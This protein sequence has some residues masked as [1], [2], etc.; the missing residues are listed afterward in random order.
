MAA[1]VSERFDIENTYTFL[2]RDEKGGIKKDEAQIEKNKIQMREKQTAIG[3]L[4]ENF[5]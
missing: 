3:V 4:V 2:V 1:N 5:P